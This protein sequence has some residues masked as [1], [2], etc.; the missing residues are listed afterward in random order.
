MK[1]IIFN[2]VSVALVLSFILVGCKKDDK[3]DENK[4]VQEN[5]LT[6][7]I[8]QRIPDSIINIMVN[9]GMPVHRGGTPPDITGTYMARPFILK[10]SNVPNDRVGAQFYD[11]KVTFR[12]QDNDKL[13]VKL[14]YV[15][16]SETGIGMGSY[17]VGTANAFSIFSEVKSSYLGDSAAVVIVISG[18]MMEDGVHDLYFSNFMI[19]NHGN[20]HGRLL[21]NGQG[22]VIFDSDGLSEKV[23]KALPANDETF[24][25]TA[26]S[27]VFMK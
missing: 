24:N 26:V 27:S 11:Y 2:S 19:N 21:A 8:N 17:I 12:S 25:G 3:K 7:E 20:P 10:A 18:K 4:K 16:G 6:Q 14:D 5:G 1:K 23:A 13:T 15:N 22:R 9:M